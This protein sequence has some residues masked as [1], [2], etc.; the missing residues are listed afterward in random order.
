MVGTKAVDEKLVR[1]LV[2]Y[3][4]LDNVR[5]ETRRFEDKH[6]KKAELSFTVTGTEGG[7]THL[8]IEG[9]SLTEETGEFARGFDA[10]LLG[11]ATWNGEKFTAF[12]LLAVGTRWGEAS[13]TGA[14]R[15]DLGRNP[16]AVA[17]QLNDDRVPPA[18]LIMDLG[19]KYF[20][21]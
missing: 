2:K 14:R 12:E 20:A 17:F 11:R 4:L 1:R 6:V 7:L 21:R 10:K 8:R 15:E 5:G 3:H 16:M 9:A 19:A 18:Q 13:L